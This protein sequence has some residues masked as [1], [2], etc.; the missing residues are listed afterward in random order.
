M[1]SSGFRNLLKRKQ[2]VVS[3]TNSQHHPSRRPS[4][5][6]QKSSNKSARIT[7]PR[8]R[9]LTR[10]VLQTMQLRAITRE[11]FRRGPNCSKNSW[12]Y[13][14]MWWVE[15]AYTMCHQAPICTEIIT[16]L[17]SPESPCL[18]RPSSKSHH[19]TTTLQAF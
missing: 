18:Q 14:P 13:L 3:L 6:E 8:L 12:R 11:I 9:L 4:L 15:V 5:A 19:Q 10:I 7:H 16:K 1:R 2:A 17:S